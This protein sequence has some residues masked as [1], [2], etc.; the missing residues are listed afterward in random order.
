[1]SSYGFSRDFISLQLC[2]MLNP[3]RIFCSC[4]NN[5]QHI[6]T[7]EFL[8]LRGASTSHAANTSLA[9]CLPTSNS[10]VA[11]LCSHV[12]TVGFELSLWGYF[13]CFMIN[14]HSAVKCW[15]AA[16]R[17]A[18]SDRLSHKTWTTKWNTTD[19]YNVPSKCEIL[20]FQAIVQTVVWLWKPEDFCQN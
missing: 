15:V 3:R 16:G 13:G 7:F 2:L 9:N 18:V 17:K 19:I 12:L 20:L 10:P 11:G 8:T 5:K 14:F 4:W 1:M 6:S